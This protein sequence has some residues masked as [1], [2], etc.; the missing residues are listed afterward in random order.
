MQGVIDIG[1]WFTEIKTQPK[2]IKLHIRKLIIV[3]AMFAGRCE[4]KHSSRSAVTI[5]WKY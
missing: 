5:R 2:K 4:A 1:V 3:M